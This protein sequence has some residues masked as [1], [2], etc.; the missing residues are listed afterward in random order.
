[1]ILWPSVRIYDGADGAVFV[2]DD[3]RHRLGI[4][5]DLGHVFADLPGVVASLDAVVL[6]SNYD[7]DMLAEGF[8][9]DSLKERIEGPGGHISNFEAAD[10]LKSNASKRM[11]WACLAHLSEDNNTPDLA[12][13]THRR[14]LGK[15]MP[16]FVA[17]RYDTS[18]V[19][20]I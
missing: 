14:M 16:I 19:M 10:V 7:P 12:L 3:G 4:L 11:Q 8:Y 2:V 18:D 6:E 17:T 15:R 5:T 13:K 1:M 9:P 20:K